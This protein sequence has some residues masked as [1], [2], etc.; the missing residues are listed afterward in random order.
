[1]ELD[2]DAAAAAAASGVVEAWPDEVESVYQAVLL[3]VV[4]VVNLLPMRSF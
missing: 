4:D 3:R 1:V 2:T